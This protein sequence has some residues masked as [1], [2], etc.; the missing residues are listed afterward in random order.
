MGVGGMSYSVYIIGEAETEPV[1]RLVHKIGVSSDPEIRCKTLQTGNPRRLCVFKSWEV[2]PDFQAKW[3]EAAVHE[4]LKEN[5]IRREWFK[6]T[7]DEAISVVEQVIEQGQKKEGLGIAD[8]REPTR[9]I[10]LPW[11]IR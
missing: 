5:L 3:I 8:W 11:K 4:V 9:R 10:T 7:L 2:G 1:L 6:V